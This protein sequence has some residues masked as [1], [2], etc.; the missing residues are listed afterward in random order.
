MEGDCGGLEFIQLDDHGCSVFQSVGWCLSPPYIPTPV[1]QGDSLSEQLS[2]QFPIRLLDGGE[3]R[4][5]Q[6]ADGDGLG[7]QRGF[8]RDLLLLPLVVGQGSAEPCQEPGRGKKVGAALPLDLG[9]D[10]EDVPLVGV[11]EP[12]P[13]AQGV[14][15]AALPLAAAQGVAIRLALK[16]PPARLTPQAAFGTV[17]INRWPLWYRT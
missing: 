2:T 15:E 13:G 5:T 11:V 16:V 1:K 12:P 10:D 8:P 14:A 3:D 7:A 17:Q 4:V 6:N 9:Q